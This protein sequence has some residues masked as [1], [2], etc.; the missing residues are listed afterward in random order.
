MNLDSHE[1]GFES[2]HFSSGVTLSMR[3][4]CALI[5]SHDKRTEYTLLLIG[6]NV[7]IYERISAQQLLVF[8]VFA[9]TVIGS[10][11]VRKYQS[12]AVVERSQINLLTGPGLV[13]FCVSSVMSSPCGETGDI[14]F[15]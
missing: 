12:G 13:P 9:I 6:L 2:H 1:L 15:G 3:L 8:V 14:S 10:V 7:V 11:Y 5:F 4:F